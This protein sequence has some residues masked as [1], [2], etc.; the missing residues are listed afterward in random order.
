MG[1]FVLGLLI[2]AAGGCIAYW[3]IPVQAFF[4]EME[5]A[6]RIFGGMGSLIAWRLLGLAMVC[7]GILLAFG[8]IQGRP[9]ELLL[10]PTP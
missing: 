2:A 9:D 10:P 1:A 4:G 6:E 8:F 3:A 5:W 7:L